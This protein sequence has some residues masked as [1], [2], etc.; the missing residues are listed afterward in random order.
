[1][2]AVRRLTV[3]ATCLAALVFAGTASAV[4]IPQRSIARIE[5]NMTR[6][7]VRAERGD[8]NYVRHGTNKFGP[9]TLFGYRKLKVTFQGNDGAT[10]IFTTRRRQFTPEGIHVGS[11]EA[12][13]LAAYPGANCRTETSHFRHCWTGT[14]QAGRRVTDYRIGMATGEVRNVRVAFVID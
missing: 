4:I 7:E 12:Q 5:L 6:P 2:R 11:T 13:L 8:P 14:F 3:T 9:W 10:A 1:V